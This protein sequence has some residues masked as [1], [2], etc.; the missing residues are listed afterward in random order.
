MFLVYL[1]RSTRFPDKVYIGS[2]RDLKAR[3]EKHNS[4]IEG[5]FAARFGPWK[6]VVTIEFEDRSRAG[7]FERYLKSGSG[8][9][10]ARRHFW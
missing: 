1:L 5:G 6:P 4:G 3:I 8:H 2:T 10:F 9:A 7:Q